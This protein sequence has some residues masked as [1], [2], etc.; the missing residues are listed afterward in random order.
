MVVY[1]GQVVTLVSFNGR[2]SLFDIYDL[3]RFRLVPVGFSDQY[4]GHSYPWTLSVLWPGN[5]L[6]LLW[7]IQ[8]CVLFEP[9]AEWSLC[10]TNVCMA[11]VV[12]TCDVV[13][14]STLVSFR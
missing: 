10:F 12:V 11:A 4:F 8:V 1:G 6:L 14:G 5:G 3:L 7:L 2:S 9:L 13:D